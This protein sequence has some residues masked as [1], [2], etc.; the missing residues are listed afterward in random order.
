MSFTTGEFVQYVR[1]EMGLTQKA[2]ASK[3]G[4]SIQSV[5][6]WERCKTLPAYKSLETLLECCKHESIDA[7]DYHLENYVD[8]SLIDF[9]YDGKYERVSDVLPH[10]HRVI[11]RCGK[12]GRRSVVPLAWFDSKN[13]RILCHYCWLDSKILP[14]E[15]YGILISEETGEALI[16]HYA[17][18]NTYRRGLLKVRRIGFKCEFCDL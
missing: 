6:N 3:L 2:F 12:C 18:G 9:V 11:I 13:K 4:V 7:Y 1:N 10:N 5:Q 16:T 15:K 14:T 17:C 8:D